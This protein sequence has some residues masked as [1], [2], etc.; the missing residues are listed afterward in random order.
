MSHDLSLF[1]CLK[2]TLGSPATMVLAGRSYTWRSL[3]WSRIG[4]CTVIDVDRRTYLNNFWQLFIASS[5][6]PI[7]WVDRSRLQTVDGRAVVVAPTISAAEEAESMVDEIV[8]AVLI[9]EHR[10]RETA[11]M[12]SLKVAAMGTLP[13]QAIPQRG[14]AQCAW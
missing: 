1:T 7:A 4:V 12:A 6:E 2:L 11:K 9:L 14:S 5:T 8:L 10:L 13:M 3:G